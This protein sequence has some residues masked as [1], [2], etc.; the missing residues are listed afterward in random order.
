MSRETVI[1]KTRFG[2]TVRTGP[3]DM[4]KIWHDVAQ[5]TALRQIE[6]CKYSELSNV[7]GRCAQT[8]CLT[9]SSTQ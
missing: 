1:P 8:N 9:C 7:F 6:M 2:S 3:A 5:N 4:A